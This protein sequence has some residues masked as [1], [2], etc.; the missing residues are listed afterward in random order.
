MLVTLRGTLSIY[1]RVCSVATFVFASTCICGVNLSAEPLGELDTIEPSCRME[2]PNHLSPADSAAASQAGEGAAQSILGG[3]GAHPSIILDLLPF[4]CLLSYEQIEN[5]CWQACARAIPGQGAAL[6]VKRSG[7][8]SFCIGYTRDL[9]DIL[10]PLGA[11][12]KLK[13]KKWAPTEQ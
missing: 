11:P 5:T 6:C 4:L 3:H 12:E 2:D 9:L 8:A 13:R 10:C 7:C 1:K